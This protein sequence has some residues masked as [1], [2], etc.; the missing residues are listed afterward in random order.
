MFFYVFLLSIFNKETMGARKGWS[1]LKSPLGCKAFVRVSEDPI[2][3]NG[4]KYVEFAGAVM[5]AYQA[6]G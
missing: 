1:A 5:Q 6:R 3:G 4:R 2:R